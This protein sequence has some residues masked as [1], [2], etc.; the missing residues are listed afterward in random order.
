MLS[1]RTTRF[2]HGPRSHRVVVVVVVVVV[3]VVMLPLFAGLR[4]VRSRVMIDIGVLV[5]LFCNCL[6]PTAR[7][8]C[9]WSLLAAVVAGTL[10]TA[11]PTARWPIT[12]SV[13]PYVFFAAVRAGCELW[14]WSGAGRSGTGRG[15]AQPRRQIVRPDQTERRKLYIL[16]R[17]GKRGERANGRTPTR[18][19]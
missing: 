8:L 3:I 17:R 13:V 18:D 12:L 9:D 15:H 10:V 5:I 19:G 7:S 6:V 11:G 2:A 16:S 1:N 14:S 4:P